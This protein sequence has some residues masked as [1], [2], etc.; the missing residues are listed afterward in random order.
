MMDIME[1]DSSIFFFEIPDGDL[2]IYDVTADK[3]V[4]H[5]DALLDLYCNLFPQYFPAL[6]RVDQMALLSEPFNP[7]V[8][9]HRWLVTFNGSPAGLVSFEFAIRHNLGLCLSIGVLPAYRS[10]AW[11]GYRR[12]SDFLIQQMIKQLEVDAKNN[13]YSELAGVVVELEMAE[14]TPDPVLKKSRLNLFN[15]YQEYGF[16]PLDVNYHEPAFVRTYEKMPTSSAKAVP[17]QL[18][19]LPTINGRIYPSRLEMLNQV[20]DALLVD[21]YGLPESDWIV[22]KARDSIGASGEKNDRNT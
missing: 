3:N 8:I 5:L 13:G 4:E 20:I 9:R 2:Y 19:I 11:D 21:H 17:M 14:N 22:Q 16:L 10:L 12:L 15:R 1:S 6:P 7:R 18:C